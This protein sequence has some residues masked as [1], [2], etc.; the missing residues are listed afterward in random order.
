MHVYEKKLSLEI[1]VLVYRLCQS[2]Y[3]MKNLCRRVSSQF[4]CAKDCTIPDTD[5][6]IMGTD[7]IILATAGYDHTIKFWQPHTGICSKT[8]PHPD[9]VSLL[10]HQT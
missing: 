9:S 7:G 6:I 10:L 5:S 3:I 4:A 2:T 8:V 1:L